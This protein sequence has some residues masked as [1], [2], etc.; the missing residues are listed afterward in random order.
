MAGT[1][2][3]RGRHPTPPLRVSAP[4]EI[5]LIEIEAADVGWRS[6]KAIIL[7]GKN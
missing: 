3:P 2:V 4:P 6:W 7:H 1:A 5:T